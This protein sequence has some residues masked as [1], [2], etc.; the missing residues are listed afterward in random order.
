M[1]VLMVGAGAV[2]QVYGAAL[3]RGG[4]EVH[5]YVRPRYV[6]EAREGY[7]LWH[8]RRGRAPREERFV[9]AGVHTT[10]E[11]VRAQP[12]D[13]LWL[14]VSGPAVA[15]PWLEALVEATG[16]ATVVCLQPGPESRAR[17]AS[18]AGPRMVLG[19]I[20]FIAYQAP[21]PGETRFDAPGVAVWV[22][23]GAAPFD[24]AAARLD[25]V[26]DVLRRGGLRARRADVAT[27]STYGGA[28]LQC[29]V[30]AL[31]GVGWSWTAVRRG[32]T[33]RV[34]FGAFREI[35][36]AAR[37]EAPAPVWTRLVGPWLVPPVMLAA[38][39]I[40]PMDVPTYFGWHFT[41]VGTQTRAHLDHWLR[42]A[43]VAGLPSASLAELRRR[44]PTRATFDRTRALA[45]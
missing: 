22:P 15:E 35:V 37:R 5:V 43:G 19:L 13:Q 42:V 20:D 41:K 1:R 14:A 18:V 24:G 25:P 6:A 36:A 3:A 26:L 8:L 21:L 39:A 28:L 30:A 23:P 44:M 17:V 29:L 45:D 11:E 4:A 31:D 27:P 12:W 16:D 34:A 38:R 10:P 2:G 32:D 40:L 7:R 9:P 33:L